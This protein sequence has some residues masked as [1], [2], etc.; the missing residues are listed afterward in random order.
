MIFIKKFAFNPVQVNTFVLYDETLEAV[1]VDA[2]C[3]NS[4]ERQKLDDFIAQEKL[5][6]VL[7]LNTHCHFD[8]LMGTEYVRSK[9]NIEFAA[10]DGDRFLIEN[11][12]EHGDLFGI[13]MEP[14]SLPNRLLCD[15][16][17]IRFGHSE[18]QVLHVP[19]HSPGSVA[20][21]SRDQKFVI[22]GDVL[23]YGSI[24]RTDLPLGDFDTLIHSIRTKLLSL[25]EDVKVFSGHG[26]E[27][28]IAYEKANN[29]YL[30][31]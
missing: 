10:H 21:Y 18:L 6:P 14:V 22:V 20:Y 1:I 9:Y 29:I 31:A 16:Q 24:G 30:I 17:I 7:L 13:P 5:K 28:N 4:G 2:G 11:A 8:H 19:G 12:V 27:T 23:F 26:P 15:G 3:Y 25:D